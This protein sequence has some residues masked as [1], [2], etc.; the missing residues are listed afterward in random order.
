MNNTQSTSDLLSNT[1]I[2]PLLGLSRAN[3][4]QIG[5]FVSCR[6]TTDNKI[7]VEVL[8]RTLCAWNTLG[9]EQG[10]VAYLTDFTHPDTGTTFIL[11]RADVWYADIQKFKEG[12]YSEF[13]AEAK[14]RIK[15]FSS[16]WNA[17]GQCVKI[18]DV[19]NAVHILALSKDP[20]LRS[21]LERELDC[22]VS[23]EAELLDVPSENNFITI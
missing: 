10:H 15:K 16:V 19:P 7:V 23:P 9:G 20:K 8:D 6:V 12:K 1:Y 3:Y 22:R 13:S 11:Y 17:Y 2:L 18:A 21:H 14:Y 5:N 4:G